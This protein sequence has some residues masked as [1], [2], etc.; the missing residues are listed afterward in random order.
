[1]DKKAVISQA[2]FM[3]FTIFVILFIIIYALN[4]FANIQNE[5]SN[6]EL[7]EIRETINREALFCDRSSTRGG[8][9]NFEIKSNSFNAFCILGLEDLG[10]SEISGYVDINSTNHNVILLDTQLSQREDSGFNIITNSANIIGSF[11]IDIQEPISETMCWTD[12]NQGIIKVSF[13]CS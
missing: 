13:I 10:F 5:I 3:I 9:T 8:L 11:S 7:I 6:R 2:V 12:Q 1:M 4:E